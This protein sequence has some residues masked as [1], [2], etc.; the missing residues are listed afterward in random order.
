MEHLPTIAR[1]QHSTP[2]SSTLVEA[3]RAFSSKW[4]PVDGDALSRRGS[5][6]PP[7]AQFLPCLSNPPPPPSFLIPR[8]ELE[9]FNFVVAYS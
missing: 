4:T 9:Q 7:A 2:R 3:N 5:A 6:K 8:F 1:V